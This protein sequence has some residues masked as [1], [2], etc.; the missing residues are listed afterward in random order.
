MTDRELRERI[1]E[2]AA[3]HRR[4]LDLSGQELTSLPPEIGTLTGL[5]GLN[6]SSNQLASLPPEIGELTGLKTL[7][8]SR[9][10]LTSLPPEIGALTALKTLFVNDNQLRSLPPEIRALT[11]LKTLFVN[12]NQLT[13]L[14]PEIGALAALEDLYLSGNQLTSLPPEIGAV[15]ALK[16]LHVPSNQLMSL[17]PEIG[18]LAALETLFLT[19]NRLTSLPPEIGYLT[20][21]RVLHFEGN[22]LPD[23]LMEASRRGSDAL[24]AYLRSVAEAELVEALYEAKLL[25]VGEGEVGKS[26]LLA[27]IKGEGFVRDRETTHGVEICGLDLAHPDGR[28]TIRLNAWD[29][30][31]QIVY[32]VTNQFFFSKRSLYLLLWDPR[33]DVERCDV[34]GWVRRIRLRV[35][36]EAQV[37]IVAT[38]A[39]TGQ[40]VAHIDRDVLRERYGQ[41]I[42]G[43]AEVDSGVLA[44][45]KAP[46]KKGDTREK[47]GVERLKRQIAETAATLPQMGSPFNIRWKAARDETLALRDEPEELAHIPYERFAETCREH[48]LDDADTATLAG[49]MHDLG[50]VLYYGDHAGLEH[51]MILQPEWVTKA[52][53]FVLED[54]Q[55]NRRHGELD[56]RRL[57]EIWYGHGTE[58]RARY[59]PA[60]H[61]FFLRLME[62]YDVSYRLEGGQS[63][64]VA[65]LVP[66]VRPRNLPWLADTRPADGQGQI[67]LV[68]RMD[69]AP[70][71]IVPWMIVR[72]HYFATPERWH[73]R[74]GMFLRN[75]GH[76]EALLELRGREFLI[77]VRATW[78]NY[79]MAILQHTL[80]TLIKER[81]PGLDKE[82][83]VPCRGQ[84]GNG[85]R[86][87]GG[88]RLEALWQFRARR[89][90][91]IPCQSC[92]AVQQID[93]LTVGFAPA[94]RDFREAE[95]SIATPDPTLDKGA[96][97][98]MLQEVVMVLQRSV[99]DESREGPRLISF[100]PRDP[101]KLNPKRLTTEGYRLTLWCEMPGHQHPTCPIGS[102]G[103]GEYVFER[104]RKWVFKAAPYLSRVGTVIKGLIP[105]AEA[106]GAITLSGDA[107]S[108]LALMTSAIESL[109][110]RDFD[111][112]RRPALDH[113]LRDKAESA[114]LRE[115]HVLL[116]ELDPQKRWGG[117]RRVPTPTG[118]Y[119]WLCPEHYPFYDPGRPK[120]D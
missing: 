70:P 71:G 34:E 53:G 103:E 29:F 85:K 42:A 108:Q 99:S 49:L 22:R 18:A 10:Q 100:L 93:P 60:L 84:T 109:R 19:S 116:T 24:R 104:P 3:Q 17:P 23:A 88:F 9:N 50:H 63:S 39:R 48:G 102:E 111:A 43:F 4:E 94:D 101:A 120:L 77:T 81:W 90:V 86:C 2:A 15:T 41:V 35:G 97:V 28:E 74:S 1:R 91:E 31:G 89:I 75:Q 117:L 67:T 20:G 47:F 61:P 98:S 110:K 80:E 40:R 73:W 69:E 11:A 58:G 118:D 112:R 113:G 55:T 46:A 16:T 8:V 62:L 82:F 68:C 65:Q 66:D 78:P 59:E 38:H 79:F 13:S 5:E 107:L 54:H 36:D 115:L 72:T 95:R 52:I 26:T 96:V 45:G 27:A 76:G 64:L 56:H 114:G 30:G 105:M 6:L 57:R 14:P 51:E 21:L 44:D 87:D 32:R 25:L 37:L 119:L 92:Y 106:A 12:D 7:F 33:K 83:R